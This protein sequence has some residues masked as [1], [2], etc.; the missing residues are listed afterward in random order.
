MKL[1]RHIIP[2]VILLLM[3]PAYKLCAQEVEYYKCP[4]EMYNGELIAS[5]WLQEVFIY[6]PLVFTNDKQRGEY[7]RLVRDVKKAMPYAQDVSK[8][9]IETYEYMGTLPDEKAKKK[10][11]ET[12]QKYVMETYKPR[13]KKLTKNQG[14]ILVKLIDRQCNVSTYEIVKSL[15]GSFKAGVYNAF[16]GIFGNSLKQEYDPEGRDRMIERIVIQIQQGTL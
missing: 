8:M 2:S 9:I 10:H 1:I 7:P 16:A 3:P 15:V 12:V 6:P 4:A 13:M 5:L 11:L 14:K